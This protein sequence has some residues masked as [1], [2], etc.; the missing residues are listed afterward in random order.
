MAKIE[1]PYNTPIDYIVRSAGTLCGW[2]M[3]GEHD[4]CKPSI[5]YYHRLYVCSCK[6]GCADESFVQLHKKHPTK[7]EYENGTKKKSGQTSQEPAGASSLTAE[8]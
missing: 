3:M 2:C 5:R 4:K 7:D 1:D 6:L 8:G